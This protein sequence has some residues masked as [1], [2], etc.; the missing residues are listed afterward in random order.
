MGGSAAT[1]DERIFAAR[2]SLGPRIPRARAPL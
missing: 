1:H 2:D